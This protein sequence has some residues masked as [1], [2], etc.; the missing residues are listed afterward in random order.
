MA[1]TK[2]KTLREAALVIELEKKALKERGASQQDLADFISMLSDLVV[3][4]A[5][6]M[7]R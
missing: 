5:R 6:R 3:E 2:V 4:M 1:I 7:D